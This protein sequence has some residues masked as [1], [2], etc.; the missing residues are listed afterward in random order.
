[1]RAQ[2]LSKFP[3]TAAS[4]EPNTEKFSVNIYCAEQPQRTGRLRVH[5][6]IGKTTG[7]LEKNNLNINL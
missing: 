6:R 2:V 7:K 3:I 5:R 1:M 4:S